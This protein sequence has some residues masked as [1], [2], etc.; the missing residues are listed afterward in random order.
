MLYVHLTAEQVQQVEKAGR[1]E[2]HGCVTYEG[3]RTRGNVA[4]V[5]EP[6]YALRA[7]VGKCDCGTTRYIRQSEATASPLNFTYA[8]AE[9]MPAEAIFRYV[10]VDKLGPDGTVLRLIRAPERMGYSI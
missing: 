5:K 10:I 1:L 4:A 8:P 7:P 6:W 2:I 9:E 3:E